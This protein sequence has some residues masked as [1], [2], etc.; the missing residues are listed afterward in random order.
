MKKYPKRHR[1]HSL[2]EKSINFF[3]RHLPEDWN[4]NRVYKDYGQD[5]NIEIAEDGVYKSL[6]LVIQIK[7][8][9]KPSRLGDAESQRFKVSTY[10]YLQRNL[11]VVMIFKFV[12][13][14]NEAYWMFLKDVVFP[15]QA[16]ET[17]ALHIPRNNRLTKINWQDIV[18]YVEHVTDKKLAA[19]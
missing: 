4:V 14:E 7:S 12:E 9:N 18:D 15:N 1:S 2:E 5:L 8:S 13:S 16:N 11:R 3:Q 10:N 17:F 6:E 19:K